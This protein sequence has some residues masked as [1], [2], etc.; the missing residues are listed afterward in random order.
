MAE[1]RVRDYS[2]PAHARQSV[3]NEKNSTIRSTGFGSRRITFHTTMLIESIL[4]A[5]EP[6]MNLSLPTQKDSGRLAQH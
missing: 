5:G 1:R 4:R 3:A 2:I 6:R